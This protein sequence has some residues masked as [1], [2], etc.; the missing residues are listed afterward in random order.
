MQYATVSYA[1]TADLISNVFAAELPTLTPIAQR[2]DQILNSID[3]IALLFAGPPPI[4]LVSLG[5]ESPPA[6][7]LKRRLVINVDNPAGA[8]IVRDALHE[9]TGPTSLIA[10]TAHHSYEHL[11]QVAAAVREITTEP[12]ILSPIRRRYILGRLP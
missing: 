11:G 9:N 5:G 2:A 6:L 4:D 1:T 3:R 7:R 8:A 12:E 10:I